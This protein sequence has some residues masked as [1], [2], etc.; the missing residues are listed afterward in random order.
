[1]ST[2]N[3]LNTLPGAATWQPDPASIQKLHALNEEYALVK[4]QGQ[5]QVLAKTRAGYQFMKPSD[6]EVYYANAR[7]WITNG[8]QTKQRPLGTYW[9][10]EWEDHRRTHPDVDFL[11][12]PAGN[13]MPLSANGQPFNLWSGWGCVPTPGDCGIFHRHVLE[14]IC[15]GNREHYDYV[16]DWLADLVQNPAVIPGIAIVLRG[17]PG[18][19][20][21]RFARVIADMVGPAHSQHI[22]DTRMLTS[23]FQGSMATALFVFAD[24]SMWGGDKSAEQVLK[25]IITEDDIQVEDKYVRSFRVRNCRRF[26][27]ASNMD[28]AVPVANNDRR[29]FVLDV[30]MPLDK[31][32]KAR[33]FSDYETWRKGGG[34]GHLL[35]E[36][37]HRKSTRRLSDMPYSTAT[38]SIKREA[39][40][41][42]DEFLLN[43]LAGDIHVEP[44]SIP[45]GGDGWSGDFFRRE[46]FEAY[47]TW[48]KQTNRQHF[49]GEAKFF[50]AVHKIFPPKD[51][52]RWKGH[53][54]LVVLGP[55]DE[56]RQ[57]FA[58]YYRASSFADLF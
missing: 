37:I 44:A 9:L 19:G 27:F 12:P 29:Y 15:A 8:I 2:T 39:M 46:L 41:I 54:R 34:P 20:K 14:H 23:R 48:C 56:A 33:F 13:P 51:G 25:G 18:A 7:V 47:A 53:Q 16:L 49:G 42:P 28:W 22:T 38:T 3:Q 30:A 4:V 31:E 58:S 40:P 1:M 55:L 6:F 11:P 43:L 32:A 35:H 10:K 50:G 21:G 57:T 45:L 26:L 5:V 36:L 24:E 52:V 17:D